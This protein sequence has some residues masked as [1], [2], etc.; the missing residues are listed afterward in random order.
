MNDGKDDKDTLPH[1]NSLYDNY[2][3]Y[4]LID[5]NEADGG[6]VF[7]L[8]GGIIYDTRDIEANPNKGIWTEMVLFAAPK[9]FENQF[10]GLSFTHRQYIT[11]IPKRVTFAYRLGYKA[12]LAGEIPFYFDT[13]IL[14]SYSNTV[15][16]EGLGGAKTLRGILRNRIVGDGFGYGNFELRYKA[17][18]T[19]FGN[20]NLYIAFNGF[21]DC[22]IVTNPFEIDKTK[23]PIALQSDYFYKQNDELHWSVGGGVHLALNENFV[24]SVNYGRALKIQDGT[25]GLYITMNWIF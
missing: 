6:K 7:L 21:A 19:T 13:Y 17:I 14:N 15:L 2:V 22:G 12:K 24:L 25:S 23:I 9:F 16:P 3:S 11:L 4:G 5:K 20:Q 1:V 8:K 18:K 10:V